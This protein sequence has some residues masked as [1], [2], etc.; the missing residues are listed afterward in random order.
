MLR[1]CFWLKGELWPDGNPTAISSWMFWEE[2][3]FDGKDEEYANTPGH[4]HTGRFIPVWSRAGEGE[5]IV[6]PIEGY[7]EPGPVRD[8]PN[9]PCPEKPVDGA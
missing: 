6:E 8:G 5:F 4:D 7:D 3:A 1:R 2:N 9:G